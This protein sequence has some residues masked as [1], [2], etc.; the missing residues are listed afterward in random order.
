MRLKNK[1]ALVTGATT[2]IGFATAQAYLREGARVI[3]TGQ[4]SERLSSALKQLNDISSS[5]LERRVSGFRVDVRDDATLA[6][7]RKSLDANGE[8]L[9]IVFANAGVAFATPLE[10]TSFA[11]YDEIMN[12]NVRGVFFTLQTLVPCMQDGGSI[13]LNTSWL[14]QVGTPGLSVLSASKA[15]VRSFAR[16]LSAELMP[17]RI[18]VNAVSPGAID[19]PIHTKTG[20]SQTQLAD[21]AMNL[22]KRIPMQRF[23]TANE[24]AAAAT[25][26]ASDES[27]YMV[28]T[29]L[30]VDGGFS[31]L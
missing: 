16:T 9:D 20:M 29:E 19:T 28:G 30:V 2:G 31:E 8:R 7:L 26:L 25:F 17:R 24:I 13:I 23:G 14:N 6:S 27:S 1:T 21:F 22:Q 11:K 15:A 18:R 10:T 12:I 3:V 5:E 4:D